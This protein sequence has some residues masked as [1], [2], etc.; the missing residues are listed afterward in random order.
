MSLLALAMALCLSAGDRTVVLPVDRFTLAWE[1][2]VEHQRWE[3]DYAVRDGELVLEQA[4]IRGSG[5]GMEPPAGAV[6]R[7]GAWQYRPR[8]ARHGPLV[9]ARSD[10]GEDYRLCIAGRCAPLSHW[11]PPGPATLAACS[12]TGR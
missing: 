2:T 4:R 1:H 10:V 9:L 8:E 6:L 3:E 11:L 7:E 5:A 12:A